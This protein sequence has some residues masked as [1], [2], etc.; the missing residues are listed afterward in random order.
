MEDPQFLNLAI[1]VGSL[2]HGTTVLDTG[3]SAEIICGV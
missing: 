1:G 2:G 3:G